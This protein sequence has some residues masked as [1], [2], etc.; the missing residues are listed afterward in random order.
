MPANTNVPPYAFFLAL[1]LDV[2]TVEEMQDQFDDMLDEVHPDYQIGY[3]RYS[4]SQ[5]LRGLD[6][7]AYREEFLNFLD[8]QDLVEYGTFCASEVDIR[9]AE[10]AWAAPMVLVE[11]M[12]EYLAASHDAA[13]NW[14]VYPDNGAERVLILA[15]DVEEASTYGVGGYVVRAATAQ[16]KLDYPIV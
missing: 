13:G 2:V 11:Y 16:D 4:A 15:A 14:G 6:P 9:K 5:V 7:I 1:D 8:T 3:L 10:L 12:P